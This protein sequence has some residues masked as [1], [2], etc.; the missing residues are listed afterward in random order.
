MATPAGPAS[1][2]GSPSAQRSTTCGNRGA[3]GRN[4]RRQFV[5]EQRRELDPRP[6]STEVTQRVGPRR[7]ALAT[8]CG[9]LHASRLGVPQAWLVGACGLEADH[10][11]HK[12]R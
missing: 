7:G 3:N 8:A 10:R 1:S 12:A 9:V 5:D 6:V 2:Q 4:D 11:R